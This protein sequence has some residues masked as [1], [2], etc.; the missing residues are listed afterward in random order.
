MTSK[1]QQKMSRL[2]FRK[3]KTEDIDNIKKL[4]LL[5]YKQFQNIISKENFETWESSIR[6]NNTYIELFKIST[7]FVCECEDKIV[8][9]AF[10]IL[11]GNPY[12]WFK[13]AWS[14]IRLV[15]VHPQ[16]E[17]RSIGKKLTQLCIDFA[18]ESGE[19]MI[20]LHTSEFQNAA[21]HI[22]ER[23]GFKKRYELD[24][25]DKRYWVYTLLLR[26]S[27]IAYAKATLNDVDILVEYRIQF[28][29]ELAGVQPKKKIEELK[30]QMKNYFSKSIEK[31]ECISIIAKCANTVAGIGSVHFRDMPG[32]LK[33]PSG[34]WGY[35]MNMYT[36]PEYRGQGVC[37]EI[38][39]RLIEES[40]KYGI[41][42]F[43]LHATN[44]GKPVYL[45]NGFTLH[46]EP[47]LRKFILK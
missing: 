30:Y 45:R 17:G 38:L 29:I 6:D 41:T 2:I 16:F 32:N 42:A 23:L 5:A 34:K 11:S 1:N 44:E 8:G 19:S 39:N 40:K 33:N 47:T 10:I 12:K 31:N 24:L 25:Y 3:G 15:A 26:K 9:S 4:T 14:Y 21:R 18:R 28:A 22:Y 46:E 37:S 27:V 35:I 43:E 13:S 36:V 20:A 7:S